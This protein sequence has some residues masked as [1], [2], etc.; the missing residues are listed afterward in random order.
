M[1]YD[2]IPSQFLLYKKGYR[3]GLRKGSK[4][5]ANPLGSLSLSPHKGKAVA[6]AEVACP[7]ARLVA[8]PALL[9]QVPR[10]W[11]LLC[12]CFQEVEA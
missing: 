3:G 1:K 12:S 10:T 9:F 4:N 7:Q 5:D 11:L 8:S 2:S 6:V